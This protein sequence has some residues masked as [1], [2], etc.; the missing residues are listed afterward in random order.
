MTMMIMTRT[1][2]RITT[3]ERREREEVPPRILGLIPL[4]ISTLATIVTSSMI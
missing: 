4:L 2:M 1:M 3:R